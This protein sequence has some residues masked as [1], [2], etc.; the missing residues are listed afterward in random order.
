MKKLNNNASR[1]WQVVHVLDGERMTREELVEKHPDFCS[2]A[3]LKMVNIF[4]QK[5]GVEV[6][7][8]PLGQH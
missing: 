6:E 5:Y 3:T 7:R 4:A 2:N 8:V 1:G